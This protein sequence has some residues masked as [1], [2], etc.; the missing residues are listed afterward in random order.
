MLGLS[1]GIWS[2]APLGGA[3]KAANVY[4]ALPQSGL[5]HVWAMDDAHV[6]GSTI[7]DIVGGLNGTIHGAVTSG[8]FA[9]NFSSG[10]YASLTAAPLVFS[11]PHTVLTWQ[12]IASPSASGGGGG[13]QT[14]INWAGDANNGV[15]I[16]LNE[17]S[18]DG[19]IACDAVI[20]LNIAGTNVGVQTAN[21]NE[22]PLKAGTFVPILYKSNGSAITGVY[23]GLDPITTASQTSYGVQNQNNIGARAS[24]GTGS[25]SNGSGLALIATWNRE[26][27]D[28]EIKQAMRAGPYGIPNRKR[29]VLFLGIGAS[30]MIANSYFQF[31]QTNLQVGAMYRD[32]AVGGLKYAD[33]DTNFATLVQPFL[34]ANF[35]NVVM[36]Q[37]TNG[38]DD[39]VTTPQADADAFAS[40]SAKVKA[41]VP[42]KTIFFNDWNY[43]GNQTFIDRRAA[44][45]AAVLLKPNVDFIVDTWSITP[46]S[47]GTTP[48]PTSL[49]LDDDHFTRAAHLIIE[50]YARTAANAVWNS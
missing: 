43:G 49:S 27:S 38:V 17:G 5:T 23:C 42:A 15:R 4:P 48:L 34:D 10:G 24:D 14:L 37:T 31:M 8:V 30:N 18:V 9:R 12:Q 33:F 47:T 28:A 40:I 3:G 7:T 11:A 44:V 36:A 19:F 6:S 1:L 22:R 32:L 25:L 39:G 13:S 41:L 2:L 50:P 20:A 45:N 35:L 16:S 29:S 21:V 26:L 46:L